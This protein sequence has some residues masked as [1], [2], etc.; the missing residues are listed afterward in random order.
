MAGRFSRVHLLVQQHYTG[1]EEDLRDHISLEEL[2]PGWALQYDF[3]KAISCVPFK[4]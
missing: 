4:Q 1:A 3:P 2:C